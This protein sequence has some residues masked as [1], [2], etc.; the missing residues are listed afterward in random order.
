M[1]SPHIIVWRGQENF[2]NGA[3]SFSQRVTTHQGRHTGQ[4]G[5]QT[6]KTV[7]WLSSVPTVEPN[8]Q[9]PLSLWR[10][11]LCFNH[12]LRLAALAQCVFSERI[13]LPN[14]QRGSSTITQSLNEVKT[15]WTRGHESSSRARCETYSYAL[16]QNVSRVSSRADTIGR[17]GVDICTFLTKICSICVQWNWKKRKKRPSCDLK[18]CLETENSGITTY[19]NLGILQ[20]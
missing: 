14:P 1:E 2:L 10:R 5:K 7:H 15:T 17:P 16:K 6:T 19:L 13:L 18:W 20:I 12:L 11:R 8:T 4:L 9:E 3:Q